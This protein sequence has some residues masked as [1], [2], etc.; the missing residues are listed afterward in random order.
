ML[1]IALNFFPIGWA[2]LNAV[3]EHDF[4]YARSVG[5]YNH[6]LFWQWMRLPG[7]VMFAAGA[8]LRVWD[9]IS[10]LGPLY[11]AIARRFNMPVLRTYEQPAE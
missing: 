1:W 3:Y 10:K 9:F 5:F 4:A 7:D 2:Q 11:P 6:T 8:L